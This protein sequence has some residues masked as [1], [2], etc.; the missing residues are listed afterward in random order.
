LRLLKQTSNYDEINKKL[1]DSDAARRMFES[2]VNN[3]LSNVK[4]TGDMNRTAIQ[5][6]QIEMIEMVRGKTG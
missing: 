2:R 1:S 6:I 3:E 4:T 5:Y